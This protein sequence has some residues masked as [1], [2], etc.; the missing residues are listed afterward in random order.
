MDS[1][2]T[3]TSLVERGLIE[4]CGKLEAPGRP[5]LYQ[6]SKLFLRTMGIT[7]LEELPVLPDLASNEGAEKLQAAIEELQNRG[8]QI[9]I[10]ESETEETAENAEAVENAG[11]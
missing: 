9:E 11:E 2:Y 4:A 6:T 5:T 1:S 7:N 8:Q 10:T 3:V